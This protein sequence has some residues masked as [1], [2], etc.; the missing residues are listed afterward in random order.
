MGTILALTG[1]E[2]IELHFTCNDAATDHWCDQ[3]FFFLREVLFNPLQLSIESDLPSSTKKPDIQTPLTIET[4]QF[5][6]LC[7][8]ER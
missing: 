7:G 4:G 5:N 3:D 2:P 6:P 1:D 8:F